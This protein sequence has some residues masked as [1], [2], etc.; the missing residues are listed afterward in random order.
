MSVMNATPPPIETVVEQAVALQRG[1]R[2]AEAEALYRQALAREADHPEANHNLGILMMM[3]GEIAAGVGHFH[4]A[5]QSD[6]SRDLYWISY[7]RALLI[8]GDAA[9]SQATLA[10]GRGHG[11]QGP[12][13]D[14]L[15]A[16]VRAAAPPR[17]TGPEDQ[18]RRGDAL[19]EAGRLEEAVAAYRQA[20]ALEPEFAEAHYHLGSVL[21]ETGRI[22]EGFSHFMRRAEI[23]RG[24]D[25]R[26]VGPAAP[27]HKAKHDAEQR[28]YLVEQ[29]LI[30]RDAPEPVFHLGDGRRLGGGA[31][32]PENATRALFA[33][34]RDASP[35]MVVIDDFLTPAALQRLRAYC[36][37]ST[38]WRRVYDAGYIGA[39]P[40][41]GFACP[42]LAQIAEEIAS[43]YAPILAPHV[44][45]YLGAF[46]YDSA[47][48]TGTNTHA[49]VSAVNVN[50]YIAPD[51]ANLDP[52]S[53]GMV[54]WDLAAGSE[55][56]MRRYNSDEAALRAHL[57]RS[58]A[59]AT[60]VPH[61]ANRALIFKSSLF[62]RT[63]D[64]RF[65]EGYLNKRINVSLLYG[66]WGAET[67]LVEP[68][69]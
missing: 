1:G 34:W 52:A 5:L 40:A 45:R 43:V 6:P 3:R 16:Q 67:T 12:A 29:G 22:A 53:G 38:V 17:T 20:L 33:R 19:A 62:H 15:E 39:T 31:V 27:A 42:L 37:E 66:Q 63:D 8:S 50:F 7:A 10:Q 57:Q 25:D 28:T 2:P 56:E 48:S 4:R 46:K 18:V 58:G 60:H 54:V 23:V 13:V 32:N 26:A 30:P 44:F 9:A 55:A 24:R 41:D 59:T 69:R 61:R 65:R 11:L 47:L 35:Q 36:A 68:V 21:S 14:E 51:E 64:C 49:D